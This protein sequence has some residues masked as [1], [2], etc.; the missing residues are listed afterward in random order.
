MTT[1]TLTEINQ[2]LARICGLPITYS[3][4]LSGYVPQIEFG[5]LRREDR[6][7]SLSLDLRFA[8]EVT[9]T[10][11]ACRWKVQHE[12]L[13]AVQPAEDASES[14]LLEALGLFR[15][16]IVRCETDDEQILTVSSSLGVALVLAP[17]DRGLGLDY[18]DIVTDQDIGVAATVNKRFVRAND[19]QA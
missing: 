12:T 9:L 5:A 7:P 3:R 16:T 8:G 6:R 4:L 19:R 13:G 1:L 2:E 14:I 10:A 18:W 11:D 17:D 15:G